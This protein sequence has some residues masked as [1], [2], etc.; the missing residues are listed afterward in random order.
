MKLLIE[1]GQSIKKGL[2][3]NHK[4]T[5]FTLECRAVLDRTEIDLIDQYAL[6]DFV[7]IWNDTPD[8]KTPNLK[9]S[10][11]IS[12][13]IYRRDD[14]QAITSLQN[15]IKQG[16]ESLQAI[17][18][19]AFEWHGSTEENIDLIQPAADSF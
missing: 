3:G 19:S 9:L 15:N 5:E 17:I 4:G 7:L 13:R 16:C 11:L 6:S 14:I 8:G 2:L 18:I 10:E 12:G 1:R